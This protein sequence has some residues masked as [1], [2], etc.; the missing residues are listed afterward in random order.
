MI[1]FD[2]PSP[3]YFLFCSHARVFGKPLLHEFFISYSHTEWYL[4]FS[5]GDIVLALAEASPIKITSN[6]GKLAILLL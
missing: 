3:F 6:Q 5:R 2:C 4:L 1:F